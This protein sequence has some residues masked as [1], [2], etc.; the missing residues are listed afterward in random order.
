LYFYIKGEHVGVIP[1]I[2]EYAQFFISEMVSGSGSPLDK[3]GLVPL[4]DK[5]RAEMQK[6]LK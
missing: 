3:A 1:G 5:E 2:K 6:R 4:N